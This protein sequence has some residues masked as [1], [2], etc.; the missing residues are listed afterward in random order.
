MGPSADIWAVGIII[1]KLLT[2]SFPFRG[3]NDKILCRK[4]C[5]GEYAEPTEVSKEA[6]DLIIKMLHLD[7][8]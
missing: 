5:R 6:K 7:P 3:M 8:G 4:I 1:Y 2:G